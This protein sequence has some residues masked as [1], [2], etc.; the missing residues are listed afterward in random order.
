M[1]KRANIGGLVALII[2]VVATVVTCSIGVAV[3][4]RQLHLKLLIK[5]KRMVYIQQCLMAP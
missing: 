5:L 4:A 2:G 1:K 3:L